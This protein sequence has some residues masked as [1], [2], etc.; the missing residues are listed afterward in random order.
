MLMSLSRMHFPVTSLGP[1]RRV[2]VWFQGCTIKCPGCISVDTWE[3]GTLLIEVAAV[4]SFLGQ[5]AAEADGLT[6]S[7]GEP[8]D[9]PEALRAILTA[10]R[11]LS[12]QSVL[13]F[14]GYEFDRVLPWLEKSGGLIDALIS[15][16]FRSESP[17]TLALRGS[18]N[19]E[20]HV[21]TERGE[22]FAEFD[23]AANASD[24]QLDL[25][26]DDNGA[27][28]I[29]GIPARGDVAKIRRIL[30]AQGHT[31]ETSDMPGLLAR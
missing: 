12:D 14:T 6:V 18:D 21:L 8:F 16:P 11:D 28:W 23:R 5:H 19:Q 15:G 4:C 25:M 13:V 3:T 26:M 1:G 2:G 22:A 17:Q 27:A 7:G 31:I 24:R 9:Q 29:A 10:W 20:L 30:S